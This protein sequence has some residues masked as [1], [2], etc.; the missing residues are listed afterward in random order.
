MAI[1]KTAWKAIDAYGGKELWE[2]RKSIEA[3][4][5]VKGL[6]FTL[7]TQAIL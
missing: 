6:A 2:S 1:S 4:V 3:V 7:K 5:S